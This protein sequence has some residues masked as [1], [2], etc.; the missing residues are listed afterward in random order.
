[1]MKPIVRTT[2]IALIGVTAT[3]AWATA[4]QAHGPIGKGA[5]MHGSM[6]HPKHHVDFHRG[7]DFGLNFGLIFNFADGT[8]FVGERKAHRLPPPPKPR[9]HRPGIRTFGPGMPPP[10]PM[11]R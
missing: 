6:H 5:P 7:H 11:W 4:A 3:F 9:W 2:L 10:P 1:M 8:F